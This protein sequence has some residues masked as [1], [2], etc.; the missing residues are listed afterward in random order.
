M[1][2][3]RQV[4]VG[5]LSVTPEMRRAV[6]RVLDSGRFTEDTE[7]ASFEREWAAHIGTKYAVAVNSGSST[8]LLGVHALVATDDRSPARLNVITTPL[9]YVA[10]SNAIALY[11]LNP[12]Y[13][14][15][16]PR[17]FGIRIDLVEAL[18]KE[19]GPED[20][21]LILPVHLMGYPLDMPSLMSL[22]DRYGISVL[23]DAAQAHGATV[24]GKQVGSWG[25]M[26]AF[27]FYVA[28]NIQVGEMG[29]IATDD[30]KL[31]SL[32]RQLKANGRSC[33]CP[34]CVRSKG[35]CPRTPKDDRDIDPRFNHVRVGYN[36]K[37]NEW[38]GAIARAQL[39]HASEILDRRRELFGFYTERLAAHGHWLRL[40]PTVSGASPFAYPLVLKRGVSA[41]RRAVRAALQK[42]G[43]ESRPLFG[44]IPT[45][46]PAF[47][48]YRNQYLDRLPA[49][50]YAGSRGFYV[51]CHQAMTEAD[52]EHVG[53]ALDRFAREAGLLR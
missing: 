7:I 16:D 1:Q 5:D 30:R 15:V 46:Q 49:A 18:L 53:S 51:G 40:P 44:C 50:E 36:F 26:S 41:T 47:S 22:A 27:S 35:S 19:R 6:L 14:D 33:D 28:H 43:I 9:T 31:A 3:T 11:G 48:Q 32:A 4:R 39:G 52:V 34:V 25:A 37:S 8:L 29:I 17:T 12:V 20:I 38:S 45:Q 24:G 13:V 42:A 2:E 10:D 21:A 23:E